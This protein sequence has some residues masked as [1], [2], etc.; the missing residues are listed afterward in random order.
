[1]NIIAGATVPLLEKVAQDFFHPSTASEACIVKAYLL[2]HH[3]CQQNKAMTWFKDRRRLKPKT[4]KLM[5]DRY[6]EHLWRNYNGHNQM[7][8]NS[9]ILRFHSIRDDKNLSD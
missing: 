3:S 6:K 2:P 8:V 7:I 5:R 9:A 1:L 4:F